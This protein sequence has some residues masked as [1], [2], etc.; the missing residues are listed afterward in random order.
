MF[1][2]KESKGNLKEVKRAIENKDVKALEKMSEN[3]VGGMEDTFINIGKTMLKTK[4]AIKKTVKNIIGLSSRISM[5]HTHLDY[6]SYDL[7]DT[8]DKLKDE[9]ENLLAAIQQST[10]SI[11]EVSSA[12]SQNASALENVSSNSSKVSQTLDKSEQSLKKVTD[13]NQELSLNGEV[14]RDNMKEMSTVVK[15]MKNIVDG[16]NNITSNTSILALNASIEAAR[17]GEYGKGF[18]VVANEVKKLAEDT[19]EQLKFIERFMDKIE[20]ASEKCNDS[21]NNSLVSINE[22]TEYTVD[23]TNSFVD[24]K[25]SIT[26]IISGMQEISSNMEEVNAIG[27]EMSSAMNVLTDGAQGLAD[28]GESLYSTAKAIRKMGGD[29]EKVDSEVSNMTMLTNEINS[30]DMFKLANNDFIEAMQNAIDAHEEWVDGVKTM[31]SQMSIKPLQLNGEK[32]GF[33]HFYNAVKPKNEEILTIWNEIGEP[34]K[35]LHKLGHKIVNAVKNKNESE[36]M[37]YAQ[38]AENISIGIIKQF[39]AIEKIATN[40]DKEGKSVF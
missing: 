24:S 34:H 10:A 12:I 20:Q 2:K 9:S 3:L 30:E 8:S 33:G 5:F 28:M 17:A 19:S 4:S 27:Q 18:A 38:E 29:L 26:E 13:L 16:I 25:Q 22:M 6:Y 7:N 39:S 36:A 1:F 14:M 23:M 11:G 37:R 32:C 21:I 31:V 35:E 15:D 40:L